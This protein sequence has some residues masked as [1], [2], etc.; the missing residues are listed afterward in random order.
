MLW[1]NSLPEAGNL[2]LP[3]PGKG[4]GS[5]QKYMSGTLMGRREVITMSEIIVAL[6]V[7]GLLLFLMRKGGMGCCGGH[8]HGDRSDPD[9]RDTREK[10]RDGKACH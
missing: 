1:M 3:C 2:I 6:A 4:A 7:F 5:E 9:G 10:D 8:A